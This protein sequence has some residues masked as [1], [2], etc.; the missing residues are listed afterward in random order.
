MR[1]MRAALKEGYKTL[2]SEEE[3]CISRVESIVTAKSN[4][5]NVA[6]CRVTDCRRV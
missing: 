1:L 3:N 2:N 6:Y 4:G 5:W